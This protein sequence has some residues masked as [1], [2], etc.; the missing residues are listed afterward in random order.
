[1]P[2]YAYDIEN[3]GGF[4]CAVFYNGIRSCTFL[5]NQLRSL[6]AFVKQKDLDLV[7][8]NNFGYDDILLKHVVADPTITV[9]KLNE[10]GKR[11]IDKGNRLPEDLF[12]IQYAPNPWRHSI[13]M[14][15]ILNKKG[16]LKEWECRE[17]MPTVMDAP[18][19]FNKPLPTSDHKKTIEYCTN[20]TVAVWKLAEIYAEKIDLRFT[21]ME[22]F[23]VGPRLLV[24]GDAGVAQNIL[25][26]KYSKRTGGWSSTARSAAQKSP[27]NTA[28]VWKVAQLVSPR[29]RYATAEMREFFERFKAVRVMGDGPGT[30]WSYE[31]PRLKEPVSLCGL[32]IQM[33]VG[34]LHTVDTPG[35]FHGT[36]DVAII[37][38][39]VTSYY[40]S[41]MIE[42]KIFPAH[43]G[44]SFTADYVALRDMR[45]AAK[46]KASA[47]AKE[48]AEI[49]AK[50]ARL[51]KE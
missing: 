38:L 25:I 23:D 37:D 16:S 18:V 32:A 44:P 8:Y 27:D 30:S 45:L 24:L 11:I 49:K 26:D 15:Q 1:M 33:G 4:F 36:K 5:G 34:G 31:D 40:P 22:M 13:D 41:L 47:L 21:L 20:D 9:A 29:V 28:R 42:E 51:T 48:I 7:G 10:I 3:F 43:L 6:A 17:H 50:I 12:K 39:D 35:R 46:K 2:R 19:D 14:Y